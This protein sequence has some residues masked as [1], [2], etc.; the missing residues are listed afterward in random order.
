[1]LNDSIVKNTVAILLHY[2][3]IIKYGDEEKEEEGSKTIII[4]LDVFCWKFACF[5]KAT[6]EIIHLPDFY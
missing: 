5:A 2:L 1:M 6:I 3:L 4:F